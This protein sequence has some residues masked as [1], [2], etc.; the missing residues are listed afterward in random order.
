MSLF[1]YDRIDIIADPRY[2]SFGYLAGELPV[3][4][5][6]QRVPL[7]KLFS[8]MVIAWGS[9]MVFHAACKDFGGLMAVRFLLGAI[10][11]CAAPLVIYI[12]GSWYSKEE[13]VSRVA[14]WYT[15]SGWG[16]VFGGFFAWIIYQAPTFRWQALFLFEGGLTI[17]VGIVMWF[18]L[19]ASPTDA[20]WLN[21]DEK[22]IALERCRSNKTGT[23]VWKFNKAQLIET[24]CDV[25]FYLIFL[26]LVSTGLPNGGLTVFGRTP[27]DSSSTL[28]LH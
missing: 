3:T 19:A 8:V 15:S 11:V 10:E 2:N 5:M 12:L 6:M 14:I 17:I 24:F 1:I 28:T 20:W 7:A 21:D 13:Q 9:I 16:H 23:E 4:F 27:G 25:R 18:F 22:R 26:F